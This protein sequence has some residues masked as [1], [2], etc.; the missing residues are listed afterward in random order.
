M[1]PVLAVEDPAAARDRLAKDLGF[2]PMAAGKMAL[3]GS[4]VA[5]VRA[6]DVPPGMLR[7]RLDHVAFATAD[8]DRSCADLLARGAALAPAFT[9]DGPRDIPEFW[10]S[11]VR[12]VFFAGPEGWPVEFCARNGAPGRTGHDHYAI[13]TPELVPMA[14]RLAAL[15]AETIAT[16][17]LSPATGPVE[18][19]FLAL[20]D[21]MF[22]LF[23]E[24]PF[25]EPDPDLGWIGL[26][27]G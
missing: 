23:D 27:S 2:A 24:G 7:M 5:V 19:R 1:I 8:A 25:P 20:G 15:G 21:T 3:G 11:G 18:V 9:P 12:F 13:R 10:D 4:R 16:H 26:I 17:R 22:E 6:G 14:K